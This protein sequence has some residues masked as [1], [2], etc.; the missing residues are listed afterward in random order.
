MGL[1]LGLGLAKKAM[2]FLVLMAVSGVSMG[3][4]YKVG[5]SEGWTS[6]GHV[7]YKSW[8]LSKIFKIGDVIVFEYN[9]QYHNVIRVT[10][11]NFN[12]CNATAP[13]ANFTSGNDSFTIKKGGHFYFI[14][15]VPGHCQAGQK[16]DIRVGT[17]PDLTLPPSSSS[18]PAPAAPALGPSASSTPA[19][20]DD[21]TTVSPSQSTSP[22]PS[23]ASSSP[24][25]SP[26]SSPNSASTLLT[27][28]FSAV[29]LA[30]LTSG[31]VF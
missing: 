18:S 15:G 16:V 27:H 12:A 6:L 30:F 13:Y 7:D 3:V 23:P 17:A 1:G 19:P 24:S 29:V 4:V 9:N 2:V 22:S 14:C 20:I 8:A 10:H 21:E 31:L 26:S 11:K 25:P 28:W 5:D